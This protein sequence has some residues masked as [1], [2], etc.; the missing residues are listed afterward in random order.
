MPEQDS[1]PTVVP[2]ASPSAATRKPRGRSRL[3]DIA[4]LY[5]SQRRRL[6]REIEAKTGRTL[7]CYVSL[8]P[9]I[10]PQDPYDLIRLLEGVNTGASITLLL[11]SFGD[12]IDS[13][14]KMVHLL[15]E[16]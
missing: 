2:P 8:G 14:E 3:C 13:A 7:L 15:R 4:L 10:A 5:R 16:V 12:E 11:D 9:S 1:T 6:I